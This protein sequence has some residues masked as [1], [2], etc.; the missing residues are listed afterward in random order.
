M[1]RWG[2]SPGKSTGFKAAAVSVVSALA[3]TGAI[4]YPGF[5]TA[6]VDLNDGGVWVVNK[7]LNKV[8]H[9]NYQS[10]VLDGGV[11]T[12]LPSYDLEQNADK[13]FVRNLEQGALTTIDPAMVQFADDN[14]LPA[15]S[16]FSYGTNVVSVADAEH[17][18]VYA[19]ATEDLGSFA[20]QDTPPLI[21][22]K[23]KVLT[24]VGVDDTVWAVDVDAQ[25]F[26][27]WTREPD[28]TFTQQDERQVDGIA[29]ASKPQLSVVGDTAVL[30]DEASGSVMTSDG[31]RSS[32]V[33]PAGGKLQAPGPEADH[34]VIA[35]GNK[36]ANVP[37]RG[38]D[39]AYIPLKSSGS[40]I[41]PV[42]VGQC[43]YAAWQGSAEYLRDCDDDSQDVARLVPDM[44]GGA[45]LQ[46]RV[47]R[48]VVVLND[49]TSGQVWLVNDGMQI[50]SNWSDLEP[51][52]GKG[53]AK[54]E[55]SKEIT[56]AIELP[57]RTEENKKPITKPDTFGVRAGRT[58]ALPVLFNDVDPDGDLLTAS[59]EGKQPS[60]G[61]LQQ[62]H[63]GTGFQLV[64][65]QDATGRT[66]F[67]YKASDGR[68]GE[69]TGTAQ[70]RVVP[71]DENHKPT[72]ERVT[73]LRVQQ[74]ESV[75]Q[76]V[77]SDWIDPDG[78]DLQLLG[79]A[80]D[81]K[82]VVRVRPD[83]A[84]TFQD[85]GKKVGRKEVTVQVSDGREGAQGRVV[86]EVLAKS[87]NPPVTATD[88]VTANV[89][90]EVTFSP[91]ENDTDPSGTDLR[92]A[93]VESVNGLELDS[94]SDTG[95]VTVRGQRTG[96][97]YAKY[98]ASNGPA[99]AP[100][101]IRIDIE[102]PEQNS[103]NP[104]AVR[105]VALL[106]AGQNVLVNVLGN[107]SDPAGGVL[108]LTGAEVPEDAPFTV[109][110]ER[111]SFVRVTDVRGLTE[112]MK[113][114]Y[115]VSNG[116]GIST[117]EIS[118]IPVPAPPK[119][120]P[121]R[122]NTDDVVVRAG[123]VAT[124]DVLENDIHPNGA[125]LTLRPGLKETD[126]LG[127]GS[128]ASVADDTVRF[129]AGE[130][131]GKPATVSAVYTVAGP[132]G[133]E[134]NAR[135]VFHVKPVDVASNAPPAPEQ[136]T[137]RVFAGG[138]TAIKIPL[139][140]I[141]PDGDSVT[142]VQLGGAPKLGSA[143]IKGSSIEYTASKTASGTDVF[144]YVVE[145]R[146]GA[147]ATGT[148]M[149]GI[150]P[151]S[152]T[153][154]PPV[155]VNDSITVRPDR[156]VAVDVMDNDTDPDGDRTTLVDDVRASDGVDAT[157]VNGRI[158][159]T[160]PAEKGS[161][162]I[163]Y[164][165]TD[166]RGG[167][168]S[169]T[170][171]VQADPEAKL[172]AP[173]ARDDRA[174]LQETVG[175]DEITLPILE[176]DEDPDGRTD[177]LEITLPD[178][179]GS[180]SVT[181]DNQLKVV[182]GDDSQVIAYT[183]TDQDGLSSTAFALVP[184]AGGARPVLRSDKAHEVMAGE[185]LALD[186]AE[187]VQVREGHTPRLTGEDKVSSVP[188]NDGELV[189][190]ATE[191]TFKADKEYSGPASVTVEVTDG[192]GPDDRDGLT[193]V[194]SIPIKV[195]PRPE[196]NKPPTIQSNSLD[197]A[198]GE[199]PAQ[200]DLK[201]IASDPD[202]DDAGKLEFSVGEQ[203]IDGVDV[204][205]VDGHILTAAAEA[206]TPK[207]TKGSVKVS[208]TDGENDPVSANIAINVLASTREMPVAVND[209]VEDAHQ[210]RT[211]VV[212]VLANDHNPYEDQ[213]PLTIVG[214]A[215]QQ[216]DGAAEIRGDQ[217]AITP[218][219]DFVGTMTVQYTIGDV[220]EDPDRQANG[221]VTLNV[222]GKPDAPGLPLVESTGDSKA[223]I[224]WDAPSNNGSP[225]EYYTV[226]GDG[227]TQQCKTTTC[228]ITGLTNDNVYNFT[229]TATNA[230]GESEASASSADARPDVEPEQPGAPTAKSGDEQ[231][232]VDWTKPE[233]H[234][235]PITSYTLEISPAPANGVSQVTG[236]TGTGYTWK[237]LKNGVSY[238]FRVQAVNKADRPSPW[239]TYSSSVIPAGK[240]F[241]PGAPTAVRSKSSVNGGVVNV[242]W[243]KP[244]DN[245]APIQGYTLKV[246]EGGSLVRTLG[247]I[248]ADTTSQTVTGLETTG[249]YRFA[250]TAKNKVGSSKESARSTAVTPYGRPKVI[251]KPKATATGTSK[252][253][254]LSFKKPAA[255]GS[256][257]TGYQYSADGGV[258]K[259]I[260]GPG[261]KIT[262][263]SN[264]D[265]HSW[266]VRA[267][268][269]AGPGNPSSPSNSTSSY[270][271]LRDG[272]GRSATH[273][274]HSI[275]FNWNE[276]EGAYE[277]GR[278]TTVTATINGVG[279]VSNTGSYTV[280]NL[281][282][283]EQR[284]LTITATDAAGQKLTREI[285]ERTNKEPPP[286]DPP[287]PSA[288]VRSG[289]YVSTDGCRVNCYKLAVQLKNFESGTWNAQCYDNGRSHKF[290][291]YT[292]KVD[293]AKTG[294]QQLGCWHGANYHM[295][296]TVKLTKD[297]TTIWTNGASRWPN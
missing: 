112:P 53:E 119:L 17:G 27:S 241:Q 158:Q 42:R 223:V 296:I 81:D 176:N 78:D 106:P 177:D 294:K 101:L 39:A 169:A 63:D 228:T 139:G 96:T 52:K 274:D 242:K 94:N 191:L 162:S 58:T 103:G 167:T 154:N 205:L 62:I 117:G 38:G 93:N 134:A 247:G 264:G 55:D 74:G 136:V 213:G 258:W 282:W 135:V 24:A 131:D 149:V 195:L 218:A 89:G 181:G 19:T 150:A 190:S 118:V 178:R 116:S 225:I 265:P 45:K 10:K 1:S 260:S 171:T 245:G 128:L 3:I 145:D 32:V 125:E 288:T 174:T 23:G 6:D 15:N 91:L 232:K 201:Q 102:D 25:T 141:D 69:A 236:I 267:L 261:G 123:D 231:V 172:L 151:L 155:A 138:T 73:T 262:T 219:E 297:G 193:S 41:Q 251:G 152:S 179:P 253:I 175:K 61:T 100:G 234:G 263:G 295:P 204:K 211:E 182:V 229:V 268:N 224:S 196:D 215:G 249:S 86:V 35:L 255:N 107:D 157:V 266:R 111:N 202:P 68:G 122:P 83:G 26:I 30:F 221:T 59:L 76:D 92:L 238:Q 13:V 121:P 11:L 198:Q 132:D 280:K 105:D 5:K 8:G 161:L 104:I 281:D 80:S 250:V 287:K 49:V 146:L 22:A 289:D 194:L 259:T 87:A 90:E 126:N 212:P 67:T 33:D 189:R 203:A 279:K 185:T 168:A 208:V 16:S 216:G 214:T 12:P 159:V 254:Q 243:N 220:T 57:N 14:A 140:G 269:A 109:S 244:D 180:A 166:G 292:Y 84:L 271:P 160:S 237:G 7:T 124:V 98:V 142:L 54:K 148:V 257:I 206:N 75:T 137:G 66:S 277:N 85:N 276:K 43:S 246:F 186:L 28:G 233:N 286:P 284:T 278:K 270:G 165:I 235:S 222:K 56:D 143:K 170:L 210:G 133:Q 230:V 9:L 293:G 18:I 130:F 21:D 60:V 110:V 127:E 227:V 291:D 77:L 183:V 272:K 4:I 34:A 99:S 36:L 197:V 108:V 115:T 88:H 79:G 164:N 226:S 184:G 70:V 64:V 37:L 20:S 240:P 275:T 46:F 95:T 147:R 114:E 44:P 207:G 290:S 188:E 82:D 239:S 200:L 71:E 72:Q 199:D 51:P 256:A 283:E 273:G 248:G 153:N 65:P 173:I 144:S 120:D 40:A 192:S 217:L 31:E 47:N 209:T 113:V 29:E 285:S 252:Q 50:V 48:D 2:V 129:R 187:L 97:F 163:R 156:P